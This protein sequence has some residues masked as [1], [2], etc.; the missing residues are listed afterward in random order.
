MALGACHRRMKFFYGETFQKKFDCTLKS[1]LDIKYDVDSNK[2]E[3][4]RSKVRNNKQFAVITKERSC[5]AKFF[6]LDKNH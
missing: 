4:M 1:F 2:L 3:I 6:S 5:E